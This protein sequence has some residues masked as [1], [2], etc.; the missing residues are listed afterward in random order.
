[1]RRGE[2]AQRLAVVNGRRCRDGDWMTILV[3]LVV[4]VAETQLGGA[5]DACEWSRRSLRHGYRCKGREVSAHRAVLAVVEGA[6]QL[7]TN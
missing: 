6:R 4:F 2:S 7:R 5:M 1:M 3:F